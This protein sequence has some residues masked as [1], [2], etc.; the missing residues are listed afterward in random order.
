MATFIF[1][2]E[3]GRWSYWGIFWQISF[4]GVEKSGH[5]VFFIFLDAPKM[6]HMIG[7][8]CSNSLQIQLDGWD[9]NH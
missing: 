1:E 5:I 4:P 3:G 9:V 8:A 2:V 7:K 6:P